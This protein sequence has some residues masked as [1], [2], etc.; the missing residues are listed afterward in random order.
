MPAARGKAPRHL[1]DLDLAGRKAV[2]AE[3]GLPLPRLDNLTPEWVEEAQKP[4]KAHLA[5]GF[6]CT[7][8]QHRSVTLA[9]MM[10]DALA[11]QGWQ[12]SKRHRE[13]ERRASQPRSVDSTQAALA[14]GING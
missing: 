3:A 13:L 9:E 1:A 4:S 8:G 11:E 10:A 14:A 12:V 7:G 2:L 5:I 6:G